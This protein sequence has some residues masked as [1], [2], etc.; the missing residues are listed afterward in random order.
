V[1]SNSAFGWI[2]A[3]QEADC[4]KRYYNV[5]FN[6]VDHAAVATAYGVKAFRVEDPAALKKVLQQAIEHDG[7]SLVDVVTQPLEEANAPVRRWMG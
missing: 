3:S 2:K 5:D 6:R 7:P 1:F 4:D